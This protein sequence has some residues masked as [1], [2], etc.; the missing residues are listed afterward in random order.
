VRVQND[1]RGE[2]RRYIEQVA[3]VPNAV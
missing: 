2:E 1:P 3:Y